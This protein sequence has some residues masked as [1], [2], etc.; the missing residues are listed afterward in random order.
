MPCGITFHQVEKKVSQLLCR[1]NIG[2]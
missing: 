2:G 1:P